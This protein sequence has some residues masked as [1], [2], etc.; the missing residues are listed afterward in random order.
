MYKYNPRRIT[1][2]W[3]SIPFEGYMDGSFIEIEK[4][5][6]SVLTHVGGD[7]QVTAILN[8]NTLAKA[9]V[10][11]VQGSPTN[12]ALTKFVPNAKN[13]QFITAQ[14]ELN[15]LDGDTVVSSA[16]AFIEDYPKV[17]FGKEISP[18]QWV[19]FL[20]DPNIVAGGSGD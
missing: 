3:N 12:D 2:S 6:K 5:D 10:T 17:A 11:F 16:T 13:N 1:G 15:D 19:F 20:V 8:A 4:I 18:R 7:G 14:F 9:T